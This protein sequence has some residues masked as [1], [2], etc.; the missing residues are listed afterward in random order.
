MKQKTDR[1]A[2]AGYARQLASL[3]VGQ[4]FTIGFSLGDDLRIKHLTKEMINRH[5][6][7]TG[8]EKLF[9]VRTLFIQQEILITREK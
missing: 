4:K 2:Q 5:N 8:F 3:K 7:E 9:I 1:K 6:S